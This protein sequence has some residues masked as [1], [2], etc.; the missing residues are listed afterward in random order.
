ME[1]K[2]FFLPNI[3]LKQP[4]ATSERV[5][6]TMLFTFH[7]MKRYLQKQA[8]GPDSLTITVCRLLSQLAVRP[9]SGSILWLVS[10]PFPLFPYSSLSTQMENTWP[11]SWETQSLLGLEEHN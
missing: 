1:G 9:C 3:A 5:G 4:Q 6:V 7:V 11:S 10:F 2:L 8:A